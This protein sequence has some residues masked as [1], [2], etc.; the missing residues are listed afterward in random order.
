MR[1]EIPT[2]SGLMLF[3]RNPLH[4]FEVDEMPSQPANVPPKQGRHQRYP[5]R[6]L[7][8]CSS[9]VRP[10]TALIGMIDPVV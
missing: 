6:L 8:I 3:I 9:E 4:F 1:L 7:K 2:E 10:R 5:P